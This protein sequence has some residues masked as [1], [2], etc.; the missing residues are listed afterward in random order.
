MTRILYQVCYW[1]SFLSEYTVI[2]EFDMY[3]DAEECAISEAIPSGLYI[4]K[5]YKLG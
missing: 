1:D 4:K 3:E 5:V 2:G